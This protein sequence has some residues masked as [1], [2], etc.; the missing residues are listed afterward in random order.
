M[1]DPIL[2]S[3]YRA[4][5]IQRLI[6]LLEEEMKQD[7]PIVEMKASDFYGD[8]SLTIRTSQGRREEFC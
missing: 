5:D 8:G 1:S 4:D 2:I 6:D 3:I 7:N